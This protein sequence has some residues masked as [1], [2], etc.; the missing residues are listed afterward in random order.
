MQF[1]QP[2]SVI[3][4]WIQGVELSIK[5]FRRVALLTTIW[6]LWLFLPALLWPWIVHWP[7]IYFILYGIISLTGAFFFSAAVYYRIYTILLDKPASVSECLH[8]A[9]KRNWMMW[10]ALFISLPLVTVG[11][12]F[13]FI[14][15]IYFLIVSW[16]YFL[17]II[18]ENLN[19]IA[20]LKRSFALIKDHWWL[21]ATVS[22]VPII[23][24]VLIS[25]IIEYYTI[26]LNVRSLFIPPEHTTLWYYQFILKAI[27]IY[28]YAFFVPQIMVVQFENLKLRW[29]KQFAANLVDYPVTESEDLR[30]AMS[31]SSVRGLETK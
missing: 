23:L 2:L 30:P 25:M 31:H 10:V 7:I 19:P 14:P 16:Y 12:V 17:I 5:S 22:A 26:G 3:E 20:A 4:T 27:L 11:L 29:Q 1:N 6:I 28:F 8:V 13:L 24:V 9:A 21:T 15:G 18:F